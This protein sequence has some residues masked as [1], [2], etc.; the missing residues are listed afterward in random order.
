[1]PPP[2]LR[3]LQ[4]VFLFTELFFIPGIIA[5]VPSTQKKLTRQPTDMTLLVWFYLV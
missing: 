5:L 3:P 4:P 2:P 1:M